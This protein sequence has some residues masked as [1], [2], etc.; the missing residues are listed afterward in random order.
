[1]TAAVGG[2]VTCGCMALAGDPIS[3]CVHIST[4]IQVPSRHRRRSPHLLS[5][6]QAGD[7]SGQSSLLHG[8]QGWSGSWKD[9]SQP[10]PGHRLCRQGLLAWKTPNMPGCGLSGENV[11]FFSPASEG[12]T[13]RAP[14]F[15][16]AAHKS[17][18]LQNGYIQSDSFLCRKLSFATTGLAS[19]CCFLHG[20]SHVLPCGQAWAS[21]CPRLMSSTELEWY[22][23]CSR[24]SAIR[25]NAFFFGTGDRTPDLV[26]GPLS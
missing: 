17:L 21:A 19:A 11:G 15:R 10:L 25:T 18:Y 8:D 4:R 5:S 2:R 13:K 16:A 24:H 1:M 7:T 3:L 22:G 6:R 12:W 26:L 9:T 23:N 20:S 14:H